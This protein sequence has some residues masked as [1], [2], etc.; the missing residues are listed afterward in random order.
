MLSYG[1]KPQQGEKANG[2]GFE[3]ETAPTLNAA[4]AYCGGGTDYAYTFFDA[5]QHSG[6]REAYVAGTITV[7]NCYSVGGDTPLCVIRK[8]MR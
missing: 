2:I 5:Y 3:E 4:T 7:Q 6:F 8:P 1:F